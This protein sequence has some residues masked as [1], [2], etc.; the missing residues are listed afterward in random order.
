MTTAVSPQ[1]ASAQA[2]VLPK[3]DRIRVFAISAANEPAAPVRPASV[4]YAQD[5]R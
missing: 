2:V 5:L 3:N 1:A 4:L